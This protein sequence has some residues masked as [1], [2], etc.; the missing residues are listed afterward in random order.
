MTRLVLVGIGTGSPDHITRQGVAALNAADLIL[1]PD[2][3]AEKADLADARLAILRAVLVRPVP[4]ARIAMPRRRAEGDY[5]GAVSDW[6]DAIAAEWAAAIAAAGQPQTV[7]LMVWG[8]PSLYDSTLRVAQR[9]GLPAQVVPGIT[10]LQAL[11]AAHA[12]P[13][14]GLGAGFAVTTGRQL[15]DTGWPQGFDTLAVM[16]D[17]GGAFASLPPEGLHIWWGAYLGMPAEILESG[18]L[19]EAGPRIL[20]AREAA[21][22]AHGWIMDIYLLRRRAG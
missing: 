9:L 2:K 12:I 8:D 7:A 4:V 1:I 18:P 11:C 13:L 16:L 19:A 3:G 14:N 21:R 10:A 5:L 6:H 20:A 17:A 22:A 15:R